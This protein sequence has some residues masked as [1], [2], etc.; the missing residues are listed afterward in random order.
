MSSRTV[1]SNE[2]LLRSERN[3]AREKR[4][5]NGQPIAETPNEAGSLSQRY[6][7]LLIPVRCNAVVTLEFELIVLRLAGTRKALNFT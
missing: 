4:K 6:S 3:A 5:A 1:S 7:Y 2:T